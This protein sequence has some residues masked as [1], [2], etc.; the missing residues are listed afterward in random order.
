[1][2]L[3]RAKIMIQSLQQNKTLWDKYKD[4]YKEIE[5]FLKERK[6]KNNK[7]QKEKTSEEQPSAVIGS[8]SVRQPKPSQHP[9]IPLS[10]HSGL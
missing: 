10:I 5:A 1:M 6:K 7:P 3:R 2:S 4:A 9:A 8:A